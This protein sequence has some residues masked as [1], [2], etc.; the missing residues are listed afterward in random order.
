M[1]SIT[2]RTPSLLLILAQRQLCF[3]V[4][5]QESAIVSISALASLPK[6]AYLLL[7]LALVALRVDRLGNIQ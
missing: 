4:R 1:T 2:I 6:Y 3:N 7:Y 5:M